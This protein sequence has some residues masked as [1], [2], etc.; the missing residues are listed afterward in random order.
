MNNRILI[1]SPCYGKVDPEILD[2]WMRLA[3]HCGRR[4]PEYEF[5]IGIKSKSEQFRARNMIVEGAQQHNCDRILMLDDDMVIDCRNEGSKAYDFLHKLLAHDKDICGILYYQRGAECQPVLMTKLGEK[6]YRFL[7]DDEI[8]HGL[9]RVDVAGGGCLLI[10]TRIFDRIPFPYFAPEYEFGT[11]IQLCRK[12]AEKGMEVWAD[13]SIEF[14]HLRNEKAVVTSAN[15]HQFQ[16]SANSAVGTKQTFV[17]TEL[18]AR[19]VKDAKEYTGRETEEALWHDATR[20]LI[21]RKE[22]KC[23]DA[24]WYRLH[25]MERVCRQVWFN[26]QNSVKKMMTQYILGAIS[27]NRPQRIL[28]FGCGIG[29]PAFALAEKGH[30]VTAMDIKGTGT[31]DFLKWRAAKHGVNMEFIETEGIPNPPGQYDVIVA[32]DCLEHIPNWKDA[33]AALAEHLVPGGA[34]FSN[35][36]VLDDMTQPEHYELHP[37]DFIKACVDVDL[38]PFTQISYIKREKADAEG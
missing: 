18:Y 19:L 31:F 14:G 6:G 28:D 20:F 10:K 26:T 2:D 9:Q 1:A 34:L 13:T 38:M 36:A 37:A 32:M 3:Y 33:L 4:M 29:I 24:E 23:S 25:P 8:E 15:R 7:R 16:D 5:F 17:A 27:H 30:K 22:F 11:D 35:N 12:A 21:Q